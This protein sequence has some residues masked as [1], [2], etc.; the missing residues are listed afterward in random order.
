MV[1]ALGYPSSAALPFLPP[2]GFPGAQ[3]PGAAAPW[4]PGAAAP[5]GMQDGFQLGGANPQA[6]LQMQALQ[7][8][9]DQALL[10][11][12]ASAQHHGVVEVRLGA[13]RRA[14][15]SRPPE[16]QVVG[17]VESVHPRALQLEDEEAGDQ[18][19]ARPATELLHAIA[20]T[21]EH[22]PARDV[23]QRPG[24]ERC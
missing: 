10:H 19:H 23:E 5:W 12:A 22:T 24:V 6:F 1:S 21:L 13:V 15:S 3:P 11:E 20:R 9:L 17:V 8:A 2:L 4:M 16:H 7:I 14:L 18:T